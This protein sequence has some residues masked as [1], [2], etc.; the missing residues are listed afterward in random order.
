MHRTVEPLLP[1]LQ[2]IVE[3]REQPHLTALKPYKLICVEDC[4]IA[5]KTRKVSSIFL[6]LRFV[7]PKRQHIVEEFRLVLLRKTLYLFFHIII[8]Y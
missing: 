2:F 1:F 5:V 7:K 4:S 8:I 3:H 6:V